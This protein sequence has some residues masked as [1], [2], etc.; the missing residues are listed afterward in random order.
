VL[1]NTATNVD[2]LADADDVTLDPG[3]VVTLLANI[4]LVIVLSPT[5]KGNKP[6]CGVVVPLPVATGD[7]T[8]VSVA[9]LLT[10]TF[11][12]VT[13]LVPL[14]PNEGKVVPLTLGSGVVVPLPVAT[15]DVTLTAVALLLTVT[16]PDVALPA[17]VSFTVEMLPGLRGPN[18]VVEPFAELGDTV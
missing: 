12:V 16:L 5:G 14:P 3:R 9:L 15:G 1:V 6:D 7:V 17:V 2:P 8:L 11:S 10:V 18:V 4:P 13:L